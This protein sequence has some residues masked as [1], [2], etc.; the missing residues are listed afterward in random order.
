MF[1]VSAFE[2]KYL[3][4]T[5]IQEGTSFKDLGHGFHLFSLPVAEPLLEAKLLL[6]FLPPTLTHHKY[7]AQASALRSN[8]VVQCQEKMDLIYEVYS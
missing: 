4:I 7:R 5:G 6:F 8:Y 3:S 1:A 2:R